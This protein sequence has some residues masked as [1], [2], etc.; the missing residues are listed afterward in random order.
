MFW[1][2]G[3]GSNLA[4]RNL[5]GSGGKPLEIFI[6]EIAAN[7]SN[8][9]KLAHIYGDLIDLLLLFSLHLSKIIGVGGGEVPPAPPLA[10]VLLC[11][12]FEK[13]ID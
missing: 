2:G 1:G 11:R 13:R 6:P 7:A 4:E 9:K 5:K 3:G 8:F 10:T 12:R